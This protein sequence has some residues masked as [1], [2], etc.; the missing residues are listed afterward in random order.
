MNK[1]LKALLL[2]IA[3]ALLVGVLKESQIFLAAALLSVLLGHLVR[4]GIR[5]KS[6]IHVLEEAFYLITFGAMGF[7]TE[8]WGTQNGH[9]TYHHLPAGQSVPMWVPFA[10]S[11]AAVTLG[12][13]ES[14]LKKSLSNSEKTHQSLIR[15]GS[16][17]LLGMLLPFTGESICIALGVWEYHWPF[18]LLGVPVFALVLLAYAHLVFG[19]IRSGGRHLWQGLESSAEKN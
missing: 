13:T 5:S 16:M 19:M 17:V 18:Q 2:T 7:L 1:I 6:L 10:W 9:W 12:K 15:V 8:S 3:G 4:L 14:Y 11:I